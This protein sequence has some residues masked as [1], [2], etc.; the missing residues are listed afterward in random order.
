MLCRL[1]I[2]IGRRPQPGPPYGLL[3]RRQDGPE[4]LW[5]ESLSAVTLF[6]LTGV[7]QNAQGH[8]SAP[9]LQGDQKP[10]TGLS[11]PERVVRG[12]RICGLLRM[13]SARTTATLKFGQLSDITLAGKWVTE[14]KR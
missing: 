8:L 2:R 6:G 12:D 10:C 9:G 3:S 5:A 7:P 14:R 4:R 1:D 11:E 13:I